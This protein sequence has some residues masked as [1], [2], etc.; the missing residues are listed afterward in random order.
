MH[1]NKISMKYFILLFCFFALAG[2]AEAQKVQ[3][4]KRKGTEP[5][6]VK[7][8]SKV[9]LYTI[10]QI[11]GR[12]QEIR[13]VPTG[14][15]SQVDFNDTLQIRITGKKAEVKDATSMQIG[16]KGEASIEES[17][18]LTVAADVF[19]ILSLDNQSLSLDDGEFTRVMVKK[20]KYY[21]ETLGKDVIEQE[22]IQDPINIDLRLNAGRWLVY[23]RQAEAGTRSEELALLK[24]FEINDLLSDSKGSGTV[25]FYNSDKTETLP[26]TFI[27]SDG[28]LTM[29]TEKHVWVFY[30]YKG[31]GKEMIFGEKGKFL[32][33]A[34][35]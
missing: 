7:K 30:T 5:L 26:C 16:M 17:N 12:W 15:S 3:K 31:D 19:T 33:Y 32:Y 10:E 18:I 4:V 28:S 8:P 11:Q 1:M 9:P 14:T 22:T 21:A 27:F 34:K 29:D 20:D 24:S 25:V 6:P 23:R 35:H 13:R 2:S